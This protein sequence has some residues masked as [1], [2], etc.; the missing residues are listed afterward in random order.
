MFGA[1]WVINLL[2]EQISL[3]Q[4]LSVTALLYTCSLQVNEKQICLD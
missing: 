1:Q 2:K 4:Q 3:F